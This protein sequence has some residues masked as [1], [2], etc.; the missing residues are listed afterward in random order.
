MKGRTR[1]TILFTVVGLLV[2]LLGTGVL[3]AD[4]NSHGVIFTPLQLRTHNTVNAAAGQ[5]GTT[6]TETV[7]ANGR[8]MRTFSWTIDKSVVPAAWEM[9]KGDSGASQYT[10]AV[11]KDAGVDAYSVVGEICVANGGEVATQALLIKAVVQHSVGNEQFHEYASDLVDLE[12]GA[13][14]EAG[15]THCYPY[16]VAF[17]PEAGA[18]HRVFANTIIMNHSGSIG[19]PKGPQEKAGFILPAAPNVL[20]NDTI[21]VDDSN[22]GSWAFDDTD[23]VS[24]GKTFTC[25]ADEG[26]HGN[27]A[28]IRQTG[29]ASSASVT[30]DCY[31]LAVTKTASTSFKR[32]YDWNIV[33][34]GPDALTLAIGQPFLA[35]FSVQVSATYQDSAWAVAGGIS[36][37]N[38]AP[39][40]VATIK[41]VADI[42][43]GVGAAAVTC[44]VDFPYQLAAGATLE[45]TYDLGLPNADGRTNTATAVL[46]NYSYNYQGTA[47]PGGTTSYDYALDFGFANATIAH[48]DECVTVSDDRMGELGGVCYSTQPKTF[49]PTMNVGPYQT[50]GNYQFTN[51]AT[52]STND[53]PT[54]GSSTWTIP[55]NV[56]CAGCTR[57]IGYWKTHAG[58]GPQADQLSKWLPLWLGT[59]NGPKSMNVTTAGQA[60]GLLSFSGDASN[61]INKLYAQ[62]LAAKL[63]IATGAGGEAI[64]AMRA[65]ADPFL[66]AKNAADWLA[67]SRTDRN[68][69]LSWA[70][71]LDNY[72]N[73]LIGPGHCSE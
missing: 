30:V 70:T 66:A 47:T 21:N 67:L 65:A 23:S 22:G 58:F 6:L 52:F 7:T 60:V 68:K 39:T 55:V 34:T 38:G 48:E 59:A 13:V 3:Q 40:K 15:A 72:N 26:A 69:V 54:T 43:S 29:Q 5:N 53:T 12:D 45:C 35:S 18:E 51:T 11:T 57:T 16:T 1:I 17:T 64:A 73:G 63:N 32:T 24:Y 10:V 71:T 20:I 2:L 9:F 14:I 19:A 56:P 33:K 25:D 61:G 28:T 27:T 62:L 4:D 37:S 50:C 36:V 31:D 41:S 49:Q 44:P 8:W 42:V 46:Q